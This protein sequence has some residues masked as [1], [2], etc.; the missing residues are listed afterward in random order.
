MAPLKARANELAIGPQAKVRSVVSIP[1]HPPVFFNWKSRKQILDMRADQVLKNGDLLAGGT[2]EPNM[3]IFG[4][5]EDG[6]PWW[7][8]AGSAV[9]GRG[10]RSIIGQA[11]ESRYVM[12]P[13]ML[14]GLNP[15][16]QGMWFENRLS[17]KELQDPTFPFFWLPDS[18]QF[19]APNARETVTYNV[20]DFNRKVRATGK[21]TGMLASQFSLVAYNARDMGFNW[22][23]LDTGTSINVSN[24][25]P[26]DSPVAISQMIHC[27]GTCGYPGNCNNM[28]PYIAEIDRCRFKALP[29]RATVYLWRDRP[30]SVRQK[31]DFT[32][33]IDMR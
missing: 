16:A 11:E 8:L 27:G 14:V 24:D 33:Y 1:V 2:Y 13:F 10:Q 21:G 32:V 7:G 15:P 5:I 3:D 19:D 25:N 26:T 17:E 22:I 4:A 31:P 18:I 12:N 23:W 6:K 20:T 9:Y 28:S 29:A 30:G